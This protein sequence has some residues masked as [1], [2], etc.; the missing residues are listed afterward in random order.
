MYPKS[1]VLGEWIRVVSALD[2]PRCE[3]G[4]RAVSGCTAPRTAPSPSHHS[5]PLRCAAI[6][7][8]GAELPP[9]A[10]I[11]P[12]IGQRIFF[13]VNETH[14]VVR[15]PPVVKSELGVGQGGARWHGGGSMV[16]WS[17][18]RVT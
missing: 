13:C 12:L 17:G 5:N 6:S 15:F 16:A 3:A 2:S 10:T 11:V 14:K 8:D 9:D 7:R 4:W 1:L 18:S